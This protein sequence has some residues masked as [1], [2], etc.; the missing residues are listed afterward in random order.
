MIATFHH[1]DFQDTRAL[2]QAKKEQGVCIS[3]CVPTLNEGSTIGEVVAALKASPLTDEVVVIDSG[4]G[5][6]TR[7]AAS[8]AGA[9]I[10]QAS[11]IRPELGAVQGKGEN[12]WRSLH[13]LHGDIVVFIDGDIV[14]LQPHFVSGLTGPLLT[15]PELQYVKAFYERPGGGGRVT[16]LLMRPLLRQFFPELAG[17]RQP[18]AGECAARRTLLE[19]LSFPVGYSIEAA[20]LIDVAKRCGIG[21]IAQT[22]LEQRIHRTR[23]LTELGAMSETILCTVLM[24]LHAQGRLREA[25]RAEQERPPISP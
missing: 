23:S 1:R 22:D 20:H 10:Y 18:L 7:E 4:S 19:K 13:V 11:E 14:D 5:D 25:V 8:A 3:C 6:G 12:L 17:I 16:E 2:L 9:D 21:A 24:R 15:R